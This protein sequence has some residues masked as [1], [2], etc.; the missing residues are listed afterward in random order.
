MTAGCDAAGSVAAQK[1]NRVT[2]FSIDGNSIKFWLRVKPRSHHQSMGWTSSGEMF[3]QVTAPPVDQKANLAVIEFLA[4]SLGLPR[5]AIEI[6]AG[7]KARRKLVRVKG[8]PPKDAI[9]RL[10]ALAQRRTG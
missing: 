3:V 10:N 2:E 9:E 4:S 1:R 5:S 6:L 8:L 7:E